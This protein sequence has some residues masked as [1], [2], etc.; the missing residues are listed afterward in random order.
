M[1]LFFFLLAAGERCGGLPGHGR[2]GA[3]GDG[4]FLPELRTKGELLNDV[5]ML[6]IVFVVTL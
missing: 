4:V 3:E 5:N 2:L 1:A 6:T